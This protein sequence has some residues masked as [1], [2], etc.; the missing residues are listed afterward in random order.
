MHAWAHAFGPKAEFTQCKAL[1]MAFTYSPGQEVGSG[2][3]VLTILDDDSLQSSPSAAA[4]KHADDDVE[5]CTQAIVAEVRPS[6][7]LP[8]DQQPTPLR[9]RVPLTACDAEPNPAR[10]P[11][12]PASGNRR[13]RYGAHNPAECFTVLLS[14]GT[15][16]LCIDV[17]PNLGDHALIVLGVRNG[18][19]QRWNE[20]HPESIVRKGDLIV[21]VNGRGRECPEMLQRIR[22]DEELALLVWSP[23]NRQQL[24]SVQ[25]LQRD[26]SCT[27]GSDSDS[28]DSATAVTAEPGRGPAKQVQRPSMSLRPRAGNAGVRASTQVLLGPPSGAP[29]FT[30]RVKKTDVLGVDIDAKSKTCLLITFIRNGPLKDW[31]ATAEE[32]SKVRV[33]DFIVE[34]NGTRGT[35][36]AMVSVIQKTEDLLMTMARGVAPEAK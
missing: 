31:N 4:I 9:S 7:S 23:A 26:D 5:A 22:L 29:T 15:D 28:E 19:M 3:V 30:V 11:P 21:E 12:T 2:H 16:P 24:P 10:S 1:R 27:S 33:G 32:A 14:R 18:P 13:C 25:P 17:L 8:V 6:E 35:A 36:E 34:V 20:A